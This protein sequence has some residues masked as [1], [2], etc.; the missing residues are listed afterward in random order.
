MKYFDKNLLDNQELERIES[1][2]DSFFTLSNE[3]TV[4]PQQHK[5]FLTDAQ[6]EL[7][8][9]YN[10]RITYERPTTRSEK[11]TF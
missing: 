3:D 1:T 5:E 2:L 11:M 9:Y 7:L 8:E 4:I 10:D 6:A